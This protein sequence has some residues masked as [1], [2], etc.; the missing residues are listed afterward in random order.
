MKGMNE[1]LQLFL[2]LLFLCIMSAP[3]KISS[4][5]CNGLRD[6]RKAE[7]VFAGLDSDIL[8]LQETHW[9]DE[10]M[11]RMKV[12]WRGD[13]FVNHGGQRECGVAILTKEGIVDNV[14]QIFKDT[15]GRLLVIEFEL[16]S[17]LF[18]LVNV[19]APNIETERKTFFGKMKG[20]VKG[21]C[22]L[23]GDFNVWCTRLDACNVAIFKNDASRTVLNNILLTDDLVDVWREDNPYKRKFS[24]RQMVLGSLKQSRIDLCLVKRNVV[25]LVGRISYKFIGLSD[26]AAVSFLLG[27]KRG[28]KGGGLW[29]LNASLLEEPKYKKCITD[30]I[31]F[32]KGSPLYEGNICD[33]WEMVKTKLKK[34]SIRYAKR[35]SFRK[36]QKEK[37]MTDNLEREEERL[38]RDPNLDRSKLLQ[39]Q[40]ELENLEKEKCM[41]AIIRSK[42]K[43]VVE[44]EK[45]TKFFLNLEKK[46][47]R[48]NFIAELENEKGEKISDLVGIL[49]E[50]QKFYM[51]L[52]DKE[53]INEECVDRL[54]SAVDVQLSD[55]DK[56]ICDA[57]ITVEEIKVAIDQAKK[58]KSPGSDGLTNE[59]YKTFADILVP[60]LAKLYG[61]M[62]ERKVVPESI[63]KGIITILYKNKG[64]A[65]KLE[66]Y[67]PLSLLNGDYK[68][69]AKVFANRIK[70]VVGSIISNTQ[71]YSIPERDITDTICSV[72]D[73]VGHM[74]KEDEGGVLLSVDLNKAFDRVE[75]DYLWQTMY[76][77]GFGERLVSWLKLLY[78][79]AKSCV[80]VNGVLTE[81]FALRRSIRQGCPLSAILYS[82]SAEPFAAFVK[83]D[84]R[85]SS[86]DIPFGKK[87]LIYQYADDTSITV[88]DLESVNYVLEDL[89]L[90]EKASGAKINVEKSEIM[91]F[92]KVNKEKVGV[93]FKVRED[94]IKIL[95]INIGTKEK[96]ARDE[97]WTGVLNKIKNTLN[98][99][100]LRQLKLKGKV[101]VVNTLLLS[102]I[103]YVLGVL[104]LP[105]WVFKDLN[106]MISNFIWGGKNVRIA[107]KTLIGK[108]KSG[109]LNLLD[110]KAKKSAIR[111][112]MVQKFLYGEI[113]YGWKVFFKQ[114][115]FDSGGCGQ[116][117]IFMC[118]TKGCVD[119]LPLFYKEVFGDWAGFLQKKVVYDC[120]DM[121]QVIQ[122]PIFLNPKVIDKGTMLQN[123]KFVLAG[124][125][126]FKDIAYEY[127]PGLLPARAIYDCVMEW[128]ED[129]KRAAVDNM[130]D[131]IKRSMPVNWMKIID[132][133]TV[134]LERCNM[135][136][137]FVNC[138]GMR[139]NFNGI[140]LKVIYE[141]MLEKEFKTP[142]AE[143]MW[144]IYMSD[145]DVKKIWVNLNVRYNSPECEDLDFKIRHNRIYTNVVLHQVNKEVKRE[146][147]V[148]GLEPENLLHLFVKCIEVREFHKK[149]E[150]WVRKNWKMGILDGRDWRCIFLFGLE[151]KKS[152]FKTNLVNIMLSLARYA[153]WCRRNYAHFEKKKLDVWKLFVVHVR[154]YV[155]MMANYLDE[156]IFKEWFID[157]SM[158]IGKDDTGKLVMSF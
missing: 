119:K 120:K 1:A 87:S 62:E 84:T 81:V 49:E 148:C 51:K 142:A 20:L 134:R 50:V 34:I 15:K 31:K 115:L 65:H 114:F 131:K 94:F 106:N 136:E 36:K 6:I 67:R 64:N 30:C 78:D 90:Y 151:K 138:G 109:G 8:C 83:K 43:Y 89:R 17:L 55:D 32:E 75:H 10:L 135:P 16:Q 140:K 117:G 95:G 45:S 126:Q 108:V 152:G 154:R 48:G 139:K 71:G 37:E 41:G 9:S 157:E 54:L 29:C 107:M 22:I 101:I 124:I 153:I 118:L 123:E 96:E 150:V 143:E 121:N 122:Q 69:L 102:K 18:R 52:F 111:I 100:K 28:G 86:V 85:I 125:R 14:K 110:I 79:N 127:V 158:V 59:F 44:G 92:G 61:H 39:L 21:N 35:R 70:R 93:P 112:K 76:K 66:N 147:D 25:S 2:F 88:K 103:N 129:V 56:Q 58:Y 26:H 146:C 27:E 38:E 77:F 23:V 91:F 116:A 155:L 128:D 104:D 72:R 113:E 132:K 47:Q 7:Q 98:Y 13:L 99:W 80:K 74:N 60:I 33:W 5:N 19:Y 145:M 12:M 40:S 4:F 137:F 11:D 149:L 141:A 97:T 133:Q 144:R 156:D 73:V 3:I 105:D 46:K 82:I 68:I 63:T 57:D 53:S 130:Y 24:R 42:A